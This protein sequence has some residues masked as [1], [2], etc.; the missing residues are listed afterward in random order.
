MSECGPT[1]PRSITEIKADMQMVQHAG[2]AVDETE[3][4]PDDQVDI[5][6]PNDLNTNLSECIEH[7]STVTNWLKMHS[8]EESVSREAEETIATAKHLHQLLQPIQQRLSKQTSIA[9]YFAT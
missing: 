9:S 6:P 5:G 2:S 7:T 1:D 4:D 3:F 8:A